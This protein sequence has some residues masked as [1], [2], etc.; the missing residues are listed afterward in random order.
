M[1][2]FYFILLLGYPY[3]EYAM[4]GKYTVLPDKMRIVVAIA[5]LIQA[6]MG[7]VLLQAGNIIESG[8]SIG[9]IKILGYIF[10]IYLT[11]NIVMNLFSKSNKERWVMTPLSLAVAVCY[12]ITLLNM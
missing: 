12:W 3:A 1:I 10:A 6:V 11:V 9:I 5:I 4:G 8:I 2:I 7:F